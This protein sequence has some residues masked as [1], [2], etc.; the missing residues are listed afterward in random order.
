MFIH[1]KPKNSIRSS[2]DG[3]V[4]GAC[5]TP[6]SRTMGQTRAFAEF[7]ASNARLPDGAAV[8][9]VVQDRCVSSMAEST[10]VDEEFLRESDLAR[11]LVRSAQH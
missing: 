5:E 7:I 1:D 6:E 11:H 4:G 9:C 2:I 8:E 10:V 3:S